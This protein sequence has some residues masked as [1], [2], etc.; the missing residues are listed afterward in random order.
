MISVIEM[1]GLLYC[2]YY[3]FYKKKPFRITFYALSVK[4]FTLLTS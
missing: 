4:D 2:I 3:F 1:G